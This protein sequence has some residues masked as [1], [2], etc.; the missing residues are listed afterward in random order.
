MK[1][2]ICFPTI[3]FL[4]FYL[5]VFGQDNGIDQTDWK[6]WTRG[7]KIVKTTAMNES[8]EGSPYFNPEWTL[9]KVT[10][11]SNKKTDT[12]PL[13]FNANTHELEFKKDGKILI[14]IPGMVQ[15]FTIKNEDGEEVFFKNGF[16]S[17]DENID[18]GMFLRVL[19]NGNVKLVVN[20]HTNFMKAHTIDPL[21]GKKVSRYIAKRNHFLITEDGTFHDIKL[22]R[23]HVLRIL[24]KNKDELKNYAKSNDLNFDK[25]NDLAKILAYYDTLQS[26]S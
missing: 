22:K 14:A 15:A 13:R 1:T 25:E 9:G 3:L 2:S 24:K 17:K 7:A 11:R 21:S 20:H 12:I 16:L 8:I 6:E 19:Y 26:E 5:P 10:L 4:F 23:N 18:P